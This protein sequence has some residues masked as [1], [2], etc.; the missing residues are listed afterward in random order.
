MASQIHVSA[1]AKNDEQPWVGGWVVHRPCI[2][3]SIHVVPVTSYHLVRAGELVVGAARP[4][5]GAWLVAH[6]PGSKYERDPE[7]TT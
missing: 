5:R 2:S 1:T 6:R 7:K 4:A 3:K